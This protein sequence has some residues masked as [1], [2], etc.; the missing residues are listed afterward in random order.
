MKAEDVIVYHENH[1][2]QITELIQNKDVVSLV[3]LLHQV[4]EWFE[5]ENN[6]Y[7]YKH[8]PFCSHNL[9]LFIS[10]IPVLYRVE[11]VSKLLKHPQYDVIFMKNDLFDPV[12][13][14]MEK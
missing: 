7:Y 9:I 11:F 5:S 2:D 8:N 12:P 6:I 1:K 4:I 3:R 14:K 10:K 13:K